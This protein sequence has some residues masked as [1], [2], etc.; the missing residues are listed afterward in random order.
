[1]KKACWNNRL[2]SQTFEKDILEEK[3]LFDLSQRENELEQYCSDY[4]SEYKYDSYN[5]AMKAHN[6]KKLKDMLLTDNYE[7]R[8]EKLYSES[9]A[10]KDKINVGREI[11]NLNEDQEATLSHMHTICLIVYMLL[12]LT[13]IIKLW[14]AFRIQVFRNKNYVLAMV[15]LFLSVFL[16]VVPFLLKSISVYVHLLWSRFASDRYTNTDFIPK[17]KENASDNSFPDHYYKSHK[18]NINEIDKIRCHVKHKYLDDSYMTFEEMKEKAYERKYGKAFGSPESLKDVRDPK[19]LD[20]CVNHYFHLDADKKDNVDF[21]WGSLDRCNKNMA[22]MI[23]S[24]TCVAAIKQANLNDSS[25]HKFCPILEHANEEEAL[26]KINGDDSDVKK[27]KQYI[28]ASGG[29]SEERCKILNTFRNSCVKNI[30]NDDDDIFRT[31]NF[32]CR[33]CAD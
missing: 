14:Y 25:L 27:L 10:M 5:E 26:C 33:N 31:C 11:V 16:I 17:N 21:C 30:C 18:E 4:S 29:N 9:D 32:E 3:T 7:Q 28:H 20:E 2:E 23:S 12:A 24:S 1:M 15:L 22:D 8:E 13:I 19:R 6:T